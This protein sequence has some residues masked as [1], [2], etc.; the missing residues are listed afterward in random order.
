MCPSRNP[1][2]PPPRRYIEDTTQ[3][4]LIL[5]ENGIN[6]G[7]SD[8]VDASLEALTTAQTEIDDAALSGACL[9]HDS[10]MHAWSMTLNA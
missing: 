6:P 10:S 3:Q 8:A 1:R 7:V 9:V 4:T 5:A 2:L